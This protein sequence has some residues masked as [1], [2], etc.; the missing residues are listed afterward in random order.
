VAIERH[1]KLSLN[2]ALRRRTQATTNAFI[3]GLRHATAPQPFQLTTDGFAPYLSAIDASL[4]DRVD[5]AMLVKRYAGKPETEKRYRPA[6]C[7][8]CRKQSVIGTPDSAMTSTS[9]V[10]RQSLT[11]RA[12]DERVQQKV[13]QLVGRILSSFRILQFVPRS[14]DAP[15][16][17]NDGNKSHRSCSEAVRASKCLNCIGIPTDA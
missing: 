11:I 13:G 3:E 1:T 17:S 15:R 7:I 9:H 12:A 4:S 5:Y 2:F 10:E 16:R 8:G 6:E 14:E